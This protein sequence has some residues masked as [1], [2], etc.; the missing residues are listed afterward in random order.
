M[1]QTPRVDDLA[2]EHDA[3]RLELGARGDDIRHPKGDARGRGGERLADARRV[4]DVERDLAERNSRSCSPSV[5]ISRP[6][7]SAV[8][9]FA[10]GMSCVRTETKSTRS[11]CIRASEPSGYGA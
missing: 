1:W 6:S 3:L 7:D 5:S 11:T 8:E 2:V 9:L 4:E 10:R